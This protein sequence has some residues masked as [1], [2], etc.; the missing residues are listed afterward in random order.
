[1]E[2]WLGSG[3]LLDLVKE[4]MYSTTPP[5]VRL[6]TLRTVGD[7]HAALSSLP[8]DGTVISGVA[9]LTLTVLSDRGD[10]C[11]YVEMVLIGGEGTFLVEVPIGR[12]TKEKMPAAARN[13]RTEIF[14]PW[15]KKML[16]M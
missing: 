15:W 9:G 5:Y 6:R 14:L 16:G 4:T 11:A 1:M 3:I 13:G 10:G 2:R 12:Q 7:L 8:A